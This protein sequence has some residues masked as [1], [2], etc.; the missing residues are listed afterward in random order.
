LDPRAVSG[1][2]KKSAAAPEK[3]GKKGFTEGGAYSCC[4]SEDPLLEAFHAFSDGNRSE[5]R[6]HFGGR[7]RSRLL[8]SPVFALPQGRFTISLKGS[9]RGQT[10]SKGGKK[11]SAA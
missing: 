2:E 9:W 6:N 4:S 11:E 8:Q 7:E 1:G 10:F 5:G 3:S